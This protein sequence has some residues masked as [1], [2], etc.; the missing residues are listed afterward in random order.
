MRSAEARQTLLRVVEAFSEASRTEN[1]GS[2][3]TRGWYLN[4]QPT[5]PFEILVDHEDTPS[6]V[7][8]I[9]RALSVVNVLGLSC[10]G[11]GQLQR[12]R[13][14]P[15]QPETRLGPWKQPIDQPQGR[16][17]PAARVE[18]LFMDVECDGA[19]VGE[20]AGSRTEPTNHEDPVL[21]IFWW[22]AT[23]DSDAQWPF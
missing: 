19:G 16:E 20:K 6:R 22:S 17:A 15:A 9:C 1:G 10:T 7:P 8:E 23:R 14:S 18:F 5:T 21:W 11:L 3:D 2:E 12:S 13:P 4:R